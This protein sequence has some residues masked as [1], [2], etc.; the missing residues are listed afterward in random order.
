MSASYECNVDDL[1]R[2]GALGLPKLKAGVHL[3]LSEILGGLKKR[4]EK[5]NC[6]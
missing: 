1:F 3:N 5:E 4:K 6:F 2:G